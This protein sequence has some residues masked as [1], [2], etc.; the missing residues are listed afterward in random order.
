MA[1]KEHL[2]IPLYQQY[3]KDSYKGKRTKPNGERIRPQSVKNYEY[4]LALLVKFAHASGYTLRIKEY[5]RLGKRERLAEA[6]YWKK[7]TQKLTE[8]LFKERGV[9]DNYA[10]L[11]F[12]QLKSL[13]R[14]INNE[15]LI[16]TGPYYKNFKVLKEEVPVTALTREQLMQLI[17]DKE[18]E[19]RLGENLLVSKDMFV[20]GCTVALRFSDLS[21]IN[22]K[23]FELVQGDW[24]LKTLSKKTKTYTSVKLPPYA[25][26]IMLK[27]YNKRNKYLFRR[28][29]LYNF[30]KHIKHIGEIMGL[31]QPISRVRSVKG[32]V[33]ETANDKKRPLRF[34]DT[35]SSHMMRR[36][37]ITNLLTLGMPEI[38]VKHI[39]G[40][41]GDSKSFHRYVNYSLSYV[42][43]E[44]DKAFEQMK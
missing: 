17:Y 36:T 29:T 8:Y 13:F 19:Q 21:S 42:N 39:S 32:M 7:F 11:V 24:Y 44:L 38:L 3:I 14:W 5:N 18:L 26:A 25:A 37:A 10:G 1:V 34:C 9:Y 31:T 28:I 16:D 27:H 4:N 43:E 6:A 40:H 41:A 22:Y 30:N 33:A 2:L 35:M 12:R 23:N 15:K 20:F